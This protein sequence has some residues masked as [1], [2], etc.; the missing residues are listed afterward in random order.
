MKAAA[1]AQSREQRVIRATTIFFWFFS[2]EKEKNEQHI[3]LPFV[4]K[5]KIRSP[6]GV[7]PKLKP[8]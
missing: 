4:R 8:Y 1:E 7:V 2:D 6:M 3:I 5:K